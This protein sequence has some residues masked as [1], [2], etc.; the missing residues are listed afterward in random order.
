VKTFLEAIQGVTGTSRWNRQSLEY[1]AIAERCATSTLGLLLAWAAGAWIT[2]LM[3]S[4]QL[5]P[6]HRRH[7]ASFLQ[8]GLIGL[9]VFTA[10]TFALAYFGSDPP[11]YARLLGLAVCPLIGGIAILRFG[12]RRNTDK[13][14][15]RP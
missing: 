9:G 14:A 15:D 10:I 7:I 6:T 3:K 1:L 8:G 13:P 5:K 12:S 4:R 2:R 11:P